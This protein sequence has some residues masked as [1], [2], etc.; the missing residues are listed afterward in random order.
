MK[1]AKMGDGNKLIVCGHAGV[2]IGNYPQREFK[3]CACQG[4]HLAG[5][6]LCE[7]TVTAWVYLPAGS[8]DE[9][10]LK[11]FGQSLADLFG[12]SRYMVSFEETANPPTQPPVV[13]Q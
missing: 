4:E 12:V 9:T 8:Y 10:T 1:G 6:E 11:A 2:R 3:G 13:M 5:I 7:D